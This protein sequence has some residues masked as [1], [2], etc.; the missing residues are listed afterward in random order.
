MHH[1]FGD[2]VLV[3]WFSVMALAIY[4]NARYVPKPAKADMVTSNANLLLLH[5]NMHGRQEKQLCEQN[6][7]T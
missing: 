4:M 5:N 7:H 1:G 6:Q 2:L 3:T